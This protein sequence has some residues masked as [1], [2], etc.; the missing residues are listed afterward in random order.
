MIVIKYGGHALPRAGTPDAILKVIADFHKSGKK[1]VLVH[2]GGPQVDAELDIHG[3]DAF[4]K[5]C[6][7]VPSIMR[8]G[9][10]IHK[11]FVVVIF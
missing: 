6:R 11:V 10:V 7:L 2:G 5:K 4:K 8:L 3:K 9:R 1:V